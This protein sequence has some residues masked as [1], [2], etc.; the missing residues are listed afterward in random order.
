MNPDG[1]LAIHRIIAAHLWI[2]G[3]FAERMN[4]SGRQLTML[5]GL[6]HDHA[7]LRLFGHQETNLHPIIDLMPVE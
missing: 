3:P 1:Q 6:Q 7:D 5:A 2:E 4:P